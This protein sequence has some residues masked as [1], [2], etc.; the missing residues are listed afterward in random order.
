MPKEQQFTGLD[1]YQKAIDSGVDMVLLCTPPGFRPMQFE[2]AVKAGKHVFMEKPLATDAPG[3]RRIMAANEEAKKKKLAVAVGHH[4]RHEVKQREMVQRI[5]DGA[6]GELNFPAI[7]L[8]LRRRLG[9]AAPARTIG[10][11]VSGPQL[12][13]FHLAQRRS[14]RRATRPRS[15]RVQLDG[16]STPGGSPRHRRPAGPHRQGRRRDLRSPCRGVHVCQRP[17]DVQLLPPYSR[18]WEAFANYAHGTKGRAEL[19]GYGSDA[20]CVVGKEPVRWRPGPDGHQ[21]EMDDL[22]AALLAGQPYNEADWAAES[23]MTAVLGRM[24]TYSGKIVKWD[25]AINSQLDLMPKSLAWNAEPLVKPGP[26]GL[27]ACAV[28]GVTKAW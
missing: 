5:H 22:F 26:D 14:H 16:P 19:Q 10:N 15:R 1:A 18:R 9:A 24:A 13:L 21:V 11:A 4:L 6:I 12:V 17:E 25:E 27:Y 8:G 2:A 28:P 7:A 23:T 20:L 3:V